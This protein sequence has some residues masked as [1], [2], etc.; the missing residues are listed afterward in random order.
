ML[1]AA[2]LAGC[3]AT[4][5]TTRPAGPPPPPRGIAGEWAVNGDD[6]LGTCILNLQPGNG[7]GEG[8]VRTR[9]CLAFDG[10]GFVNRWERGDGRIDFYAFVNERILTVR[11]AGPDR[12][13][14]RLART[15]GRVVMR[16]R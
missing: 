5:E 4:I 9:N 10:L 2:G 8:R 11:R 14:G 3:T 1:M 16:R 12:F 15:G 13:R 6:F 7:R